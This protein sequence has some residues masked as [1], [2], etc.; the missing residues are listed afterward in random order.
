MENEEEIHIK[1]SKKI[2]SEENSSN[3]L[4]FISSLIWDGNLIEAKAQLL[5]LPPTF[6]IQLLLLECKMIRVLLSAEHRL[7]MEFLESL[8]ELVI[9]L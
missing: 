7:Y 9:V 6:F 2:I 8:N 4:Y 5:Q 3:P 1:S